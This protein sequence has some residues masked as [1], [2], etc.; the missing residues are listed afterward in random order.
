M[1]RKILKEIKTR[2]KMA[3][4]NRLRDVILFGSEARGDARSDSDIDILVLLDEPIDFGRDLE[5]N[6]NALYSL[7]RKIGRRISAKPIG[8]TEYQ[9][10]DCPLYR[11]S[12]R[13]GIYV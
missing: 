2:L 4:K 11:N 13:E 10:Y 1:E 7:S 5:T 9:E 8:F 3:H 6:L 12:R